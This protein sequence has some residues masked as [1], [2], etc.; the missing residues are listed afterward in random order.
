MKH[1][2][3]VLYVTVDTQ[4]SF[5]CSC[6]WELSPEEGENWRLRSSSGTSFDED[7]RH[8][9]ESGWT[10]NFSHGFAVEGLDRD[11]EGAAL[12]ETLSQD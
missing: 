10:P 4:R 5:S 8:W 3:H 7:V 2:K 6:G 9:L 1:L 12:R 11:W